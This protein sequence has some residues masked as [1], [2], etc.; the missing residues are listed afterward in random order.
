MVGC[1]FHR[2]RLPQ[3]KPS[4]A[5]ML[6]RG[7]QVRSLA[8]NSDPTP[9]SLGILI[10]HLLQIAFWEQFYVVGPMIL[11]PPPIASEKNERSE[12]ESDF[13]KEAPLI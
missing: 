3:Q 8:A 2:T 5:L 7:K 4:L 12:R 11:T 1:L 13:P 10:A 6:S 9:N